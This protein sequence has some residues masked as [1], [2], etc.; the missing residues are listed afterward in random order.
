MS[1]FEG[2]AAAARS[3]PSCV[4]VGGHDHNGHPVGGCSPSC[5]WLFS[6]PMT[7]P[8]ATAP[9]IVASY[10][11]IVAMGPQGRTGSACVSKST[12]A[13]KAARSS[14]RPDTPRQSRPLVS[15]R[16]NSTSQR[17]PLVLYSTCSDRPSKVYGVIQG[18]NRRSVFGGWRASVERRGNVSAKCSPVPH[19][20]SMLLCNA[21][22]DDGFPC[23][24]VFA[25]SPVADRQTKSV[26]I[27]R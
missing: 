19:V 7:T 8:T 2:L 5:A 21:V 4:P 14:H 22:L 3:I 20:A 17:W 27:S 18:P 6:V 24:C 16:T 13:M 9:M 26:R 15:R 11:R 10:R 25:R 23:D 1:S 12:C